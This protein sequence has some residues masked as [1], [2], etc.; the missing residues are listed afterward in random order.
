MLPLYFVDGVD[1][2]GQ[3]ER[4]NPYKLDSFEIKFKIIGQCPFTSRYFVQIIYQKDGVYAKITD[5][6]KS[7]G[8]AKKIT[9]ESDTSM[10]PSVATSNASAT[11]I[12]GGESII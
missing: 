9:E 12:S 7:I 6:H 4:L 11:Q 3:T 2:L 1:D 5:F 8:T 10:T